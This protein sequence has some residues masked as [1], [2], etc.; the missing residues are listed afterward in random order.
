MVKDAAGFQALLNLARHYST[1]ARKKNPKAGIRQLLLPQA[2]SRSRFMVMTTTVLSAIVAAWVAPGKP[3]KAGE[4]RYTAEN[5]PAAKQL[6][7]RKIAILKGLEVK[8][9]IEHPFN[10]LN[11]DQIQSRPIDLWRLLYPGI[12]SS[13]NERL[14]FRQSGVTDGY[15]FL[16]YFHDTL[17]PTAS[18]QINVDKKLK[19]GYADWRSETLSSPTSSFQEAASLDK[20]AGARDYERKPGLSGIKGHKGLTFFLIKLQGS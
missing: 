18:S 8:S 15:S 13:L 7:D 2:N 1:V 6:T 4:V 11:Q 17:K 10:W 20:L 14:L 19:F 9:G 16:A 5:S 3:L 12:S